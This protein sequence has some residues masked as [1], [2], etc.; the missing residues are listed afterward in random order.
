MSNGIIGFVRSL[1][2]STEKRRLISLMEAVYSDLEKNILPSLQMEDSLVK[3]QAI[4]GKL[5]M[6]LGGANGPKDYKGQPIAYLRDTAEFMLD[7][8]NN[9]IDLMDKAFAKSIEVEGLDYK[10]AHLMHLVTGFVFATEFISK[11]TY[12]LSASAVD[13]LYR[14][15]SIEREYSDY[16]NESET[17]ISFA[18]FTSVLRTKPKDLARDLDKIKNISFDPETHEMMQRVHNANKLDPFRMGAIPIIFELTQFFGEIQNDL[19]R[20]NRELTAARLKST[21][22]QIMLLEAEARDASPEERKVIEKQI[23][24]WRTQV[25]KLETRLEEI[26]DV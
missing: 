24:Y 15:G 2:P 23:A 8:K 25:T 13:K 1:F 3:D 12:V 16:L 10:R 22:Y 19:I 14:K 9:M 21:Q 26:N 6:Y 4:Y 5:D 7:Q 18:I 17:Q 20:A 11:L